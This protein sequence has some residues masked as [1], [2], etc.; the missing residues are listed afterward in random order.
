MI[1]QAR[2]GFVTVARVCLGVW[3]NS[4]YAGGGGNVGGAGNEKSLTSE[5]KG[6]YG[7][8]GTAH[9]THNMR[10]RSE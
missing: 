4:S 2:K 9:A 3:L 6:S 5:G 10:I 7:G 1:F 8:G